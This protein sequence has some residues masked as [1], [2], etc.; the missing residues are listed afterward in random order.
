MQENAPRGP[1]RQNA[2]LLN[3]IKLICPVQFHLQ[4]EF[5]SQL[6][7]ITSRTLAVPFLWRGVSRSSRTLERDAM[8]A[9]G[10]KDEG[11]PFRLR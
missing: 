8:D 10:A 6:T 4:K 7:Q 11:A 9:G 1:V 5:A 2:K 3:R